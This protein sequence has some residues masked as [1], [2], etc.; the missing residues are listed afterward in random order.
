MLKCFSLLLLLLNACS[1][2]APE[3][4]HYSDRPNSPNYLPP[5]S[6]VIET[7]DKDMSRCTDLGVVKGEAKYGG[8]MGGGQGLRLAQDQAMAKAK[9]LGATHLIW[10]KLDTTFWGANVDGH[11][12]HCD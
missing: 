9:E 10:G 4:D 3:P 12:Y 5:I 1:T 7:K 6:S 11:V 2:S 8:S